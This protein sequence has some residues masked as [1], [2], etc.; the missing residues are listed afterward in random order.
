VTVNTRGRAEEEEAQMVNEL[1]EA[2]TGLLT[3][4]AGMAFQQQVIEKMKAAGYQVVN[5]ARA[6]NGAV[7][8]NVEV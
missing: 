2:I 5:E 3:G 7:V 8:I 4:L 6:P 1:Q